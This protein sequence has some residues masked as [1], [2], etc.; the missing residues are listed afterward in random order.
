MEA[1]PLPGGHRAARE[2][3]PVKFTGRIRFDDMDTGDLDISVEVDDTHVHLAS[4]DESLGSWC[5]ADVMAERV[6]ANQFVLDL[7][8]E[9]ISFIADDQVNFAYGA[10]QQMAEGW[11]RYHSMN[12]LLRGR[13]IASA[14]R[15]NQPSRLTEARA[16]F[17]AAR[18]ALREPRVIEDMDLPAVSTGNV[19]PSGPET[20]AID[21]DLDVHP[22]TGNGAPPER[23]VSA[24]WR[25]VEAASSVPVPVPEQPP[26]EES[27]VEKPVEASPVRDEDVAAASAAAPAPEAP[28]EERP[29]EKLVEA[30]PV[31]DEDVAAASAPAP[32]PEAPVEERPVEKLVEATPVPD[33]DAAAASAPAPEPQAP[34]EERPVEPPV[35][36]TPVPDEDAAAASA[37]APE[38]EVV[39]SVEESEPDRVEAPIDSPGTSA[40]DPA[41]SSR[42]PRLDAL[43][44][45]Q[46]VV[47]ATTAEGEGDIQA[48]PADAGEG[49][50]STVEVA[51]VDPVEEPGSRH[52][53]SEPAAT[54]EPPSVDAEEPG[55]DLV[56]PRDAEP[57]EPTIRFHQLPR[58]PRDGSPGEPDGTDDEV[59]EHRA[60]GRHR[61][62]APAAPTQTF[63]DGHHPHETSGV[64]AS[65]RSVFRRSQK[66]AHDHTFVESTTAVGI[67]RRVCLE[68]GHVSIGVD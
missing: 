15:H 13:A 39:S 27:P 5:L 30:S 37:P 52:L 18:E 41:V 32:A 47:P 68:C 23:A 63:R 25:R 38:P 31:R 10:V 20:A 40:S 28:M 60:G 49:S 56:A 53:E 51:P 24:F 2:R 55:P 26:V 64:R 45:R 58:H 17:A 57:D 43:P 44:R 6:V 9:K 14:R 1:E 61:T 66:T 4:A 33:E 59:P 42:L 16:A 29:V 65:L 54:T 50:G 22:S 36:A 12:L 8:G 48:S 62:P 7:G 34:V 46:E 67:T 11:A 35:E 19:S 3:G 21:A